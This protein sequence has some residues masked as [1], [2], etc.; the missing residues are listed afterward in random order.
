MCLIECYFQENPSCHPVA[1]PGCCVVPQCDERGRDPAVFVSDE[2]PGVYR[3]TQILKDD[4]DRYI[5]PFRSLTTLPNGRRLMY[6]STH[7]DSMYPSQWSS[8]LADN[9]GPYSFPF[10]LGFE[11]EIPWKKDLQWQAST[12]RF[13]LLC[14]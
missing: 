4:R 9:P 8:E 11:S 10:P 3:E 7:P 12:D 13:I 6:D 1:A 5:D 14:A 2:Y